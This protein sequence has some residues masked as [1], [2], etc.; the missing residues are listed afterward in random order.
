MIFRCRLYSCAFMPLKTRC[1][2]T[3]KAR[4]S[5]FKSRFCFSR[6]FFFLTNG[7]NLGF[8][9]TEILHQWNVA[10]TYPG[11]GTA[12]NA[13]GDIVGCRFIMLLAFTE[14]VKLLRQKIGRAGIGTGATANTAFFFLRFTHFTGRRR[15]QAVADL[16]DGN[17]QPGQGKAHQ[18]TAHDHHLVSRRTETCIIEQVTN[19]RTQSRPNVARA[20]DCFAR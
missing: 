8:F 4:L 12:F 19:R 10:W 17:I 3:F 11:A 6:S 16:H 20:A 9:L 5:G 13:V 7:V 15:K 14:P 2:F 1:F 18:R